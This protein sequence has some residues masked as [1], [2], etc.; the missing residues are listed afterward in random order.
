[1]VIL[2]RAGVRRLRGKR[3]PTHAYS[4]L[5]V[6]LL[7]DVKRILQAVSISALLLGLAPAAHAQV[8]FDVRIGTPPPAPRAYRVP[9]RPGPGYEWV[10]GYWYPVNGRYQWHNGYWTRPPYAD[11]YWVAPYYGNGR[12]Y[13]GHWEGGRGDVHHDH[14]WDQSRERDGRWSYGEASPRGTSGS[15]PT[16]RQRGYESN[17]AMT[18][19]QAQ[20]IVRSAYQNVLGRDPDPASAGWVNRVFNDHWSQ[21]QLEN[22]L[23]NSTEY[24]Q[25]HRR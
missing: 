8:S 24:R 1:M 5:T 13:T 4:G 19:A 15:Y 7:I 9:P 10:D 2:P 21:Q 3:F 22:E 20:A 12:Y 6:A 18:Q 23:R 11:A 25:K 17:G 16:S 14:G